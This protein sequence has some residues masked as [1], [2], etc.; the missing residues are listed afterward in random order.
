MGR[1]PKVA[2]WVVSIIVVVVLAAFVFQKQIFTFMATKIIQ[3][4]LLSQTYKKDDGLY[5]GLAG[6]G[7]PF[8][9]INRVGPC[10]VVEAG[11]N[12]YIIDGGPGS[13]R[14]IGLMGFDIGKVNAILLTHFHSDHI[15]DLGEMMLQGWEGGSNEKPVDLIGKKEVETVVKEINHAYSLDAG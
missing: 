2:I 10:I 5:A 13:A 8:A 9:D 14:N 15:A 7:A 6:T 11:N 4:R 1:L 12:L 3:Q